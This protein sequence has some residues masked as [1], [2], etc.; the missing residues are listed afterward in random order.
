MRTAAGHPTARFL[1][2]RSE[3]VKPTLRGPNALRRV[4]ATALLSAIACLCSPAAFA[5]WSPSATANLGMGFGSIALSQSILSGTRRLGNPGQPANANQHA[6]LLNTMTPAQIDTALGYTPDPQ[7]SAQVRADLIDSLSRQNAALRPLL[8]KAFANDAVLQQFER[9]V[10]THGYSSHNVADA[11]A[12]ALWSSWQIVHGA[13]LNEA[14]IRAVHQ[15]LRAVFLQ[16]PDL[17]SI[18]GA[19]RQKLAEGMAYLTMIEAD[20]MRNSDPV[21]LAQARQNASANIKTVLGVDLS[22]LE[23]TA[24]RGLR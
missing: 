14:Q 23:V 8:E 22:R 24:D 9:F 6:A 11:V 7:V 21:R 12:A 3:V 2:D 10:T 19:R 13:A 17:R 15:Q 5:Q 16:T 18:T 1:A 20:S 4:S